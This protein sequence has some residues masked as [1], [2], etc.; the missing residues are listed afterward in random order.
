[1][2][3]PCKCAITGEKGTTD[4]FVKIGKKYYKSQEIY[5]KWQEEKNKRTVKCSITG[6][7]GTTDTFVKIGGKYYKSQAIYDAAQKS[8][9]K[10]RELIDY[11]CRE[12]LG[13][14]DGQPFPTSLPQKLNELSFYDNDV[15][16]EAFKQCAS[17]IHYQMEHKQFSTEYNKVAYMFAIVKNIIA[18]VNTDFQRKA[19]QENIIKSTEIECGDLSSIGTKTRGKDISSFLDEDEF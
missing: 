17:E 13:Y 11:V 1:M 5:D 18:D 7:V 10:R 9:A 15:I 6:E 19:K 3:R 4:T 8:K 14:G 16:L 12:F 2:A